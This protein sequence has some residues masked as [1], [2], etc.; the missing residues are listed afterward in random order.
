VSED[1]Y[2]NGNQCLSLSQSA[3]TMIGTQCVAIQE[4]RVYRCISLNIMRSFRDSMSLG[5]SFVK[6]GGRT[7]FLVSQSSVAPLVSE[8]GVHGLADNGGLGVQGK[9]LEFLGGNGQDALI[10]TIVTCSVDRRSRGRKTALTRIRKP[11]RHRVHEV[12][13]RLSRTC[14]KP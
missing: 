5:L 2:C 12:K 8:I 1:I 9:V 3:F 4:T 6:R 10:A 11:Q 14:F 7:W 13:L